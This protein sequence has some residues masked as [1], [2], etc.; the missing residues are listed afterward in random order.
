MLWKKAICGICPSGCWVE[1]VLK[2]GRLVEIRQD[3]SHPLGMICRRGQHAPEIVYSKNR[4]K[5]PMMRTGPKGKYEFKRISWDEAYDAIVENLNG[6][7][8]IL[9]NF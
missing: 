8:R 3:T 7:K 4:L 6:I 5:Y 9:E 2:N 1:V